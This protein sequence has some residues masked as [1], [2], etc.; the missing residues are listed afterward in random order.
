MT[1]TQKI[2]IGLAVPVLVCLFIAGV[3]FGAAVIGFKSAV[4]AGNEAATIQ[5]LKT[6]SAIEI[7]YYNTHERQ[8][9]TFEDLIRQKFLNERFKGEPPITDGYVF[10]LKVSQVTGNG[11]SSYVLTA[12]PQ[13]S[14]T[15][16]N[17]FYLDSS[18][19]EICVNPDRR[20]GPNDPPLNR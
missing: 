1:R 10:T 16:T 12:D 20:A 11:R 6:I 15:G 8:F 19:T 7:Q 17:H 13:D 14:K 18:L 3:L 5:D 9:G 2:V 4:R